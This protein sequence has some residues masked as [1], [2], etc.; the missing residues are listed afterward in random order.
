MRKSCFQTDNSNY[1]VASKKR[2]I[3]SIY[4]ILIELKQKIKT[5]LVFYFDIDITT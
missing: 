1:R 3:S 2:Y 4:L 5:V